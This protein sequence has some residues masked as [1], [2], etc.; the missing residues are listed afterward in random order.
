M[1]IMCFYFLKSI[2]GNLLFDHLLSR[3][4]IIVG[5]CYILLELCDTTGGGWGQNGIGGEF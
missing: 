1:E 2:Y 5:D 4:V 3:I